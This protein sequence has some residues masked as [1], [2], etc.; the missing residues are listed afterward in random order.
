MQIIE[1]YDLSYHQ[2]YQIHVA[3][4]LLWI[5]DERN[6]SILIKSYIPGSIERLAA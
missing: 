6:V 3:A 4:G 2:K 1:S 5:N